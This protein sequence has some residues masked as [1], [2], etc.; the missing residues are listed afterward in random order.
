MLLI[1]KYFLP[2][3]N[4]K[5]NFSNIKLIKQLKPRERLK[6]VA[7]IIE[8][9]AIKINF[10]PGIDAHES[11]LDSLEIEKFSSFNYRATLC[12]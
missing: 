7:S 10:P 4:E 5:I 3:L 8:E 9:I 2:N 12:N 6:K 11:C 1:K